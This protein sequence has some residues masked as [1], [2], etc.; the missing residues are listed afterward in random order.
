V[1]P[2][3]LAQVVAS[4]STWQPPAA[5]ENRIEATRAA[6]RRLQQKGEQPA[7][8]GRR[9][10]TF[11]EGRACREL[12]YQRLLGSRSTRALRTV[13]SGAHPSTSTAPLDS[14]PAARTLDAGELV[15]VGRHRMRYSRC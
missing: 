15:G 10:T 2:R 4:T 1:S 14:P 13:P 11:G 3:Q 6:Y 12:T 8:R 5:A 7:A 9:R